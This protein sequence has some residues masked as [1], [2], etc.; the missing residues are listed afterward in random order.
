MSL[1]IHRWVFI[2]LGGLSLLV[3]IIGIFLPIL[4]TTPLVILAAYFF[5]K[6]S[7]K[8][9]RWL[10]QN[11][12]FGEMITKWERYKVIPLKAKI[13]ATLI[14]VPLFAYTLTFVD[15][16]ITVKIIVA[17]TGVYAL[18]FIW[19]KKSTIPKTTE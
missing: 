10:V 17:L 8:I 5:S 16:P 3:G 19:S 7:Q 9:H 13:W 11:P 12:Y 4:P 18:Y 15:V 14:I 1:A 2:F 6:G